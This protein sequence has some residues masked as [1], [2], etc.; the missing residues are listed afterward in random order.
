MKR[1]MFLQIYNIW[2]KLKSFSKPK[3]W[4]W[5]SLNKLDN[6]I[7]HAFHIA[8]LSSEWFENYKKTLASEE[9]KNSL[10]YKFK[11][12]LRRKINIFS[13][14]KPIKKENSNYDEKLEKRTEIDYNQFITDSLIADTLGIAEMVD[15]NEVMKDEEKYS[16]SF[17]NEEKIN[18]KDK[19]ERKIENEINSKKS[20]KEILFNDKYNKV[21][22]TSVA[23]IYIENKDFF[24]LWLDKK[25]ESQDDDISGFNK[26]VNYLKS[27]KIP[28]KILVRDITLDYDNPIFNTKITLLDPT[29]KGVKD[30]Y[31]NF[32]KQ[33]W[34]N[35][36]KF[37]N[38]K[39]IITE[40]KRKKIPIYKIFYTK[41]I[42][43]F[44]NFQITLRCTSPIR[45]EELSLIRSKLNGIFDISLFNPAQLRLSAIRWNIERDMWYSINGANINYPFA[46]KSFH[47]L[48]CH[49]LNKDWKIKYNKLNNKINFNTFKDILFNN[50][51][52]NKNSIG[53][54]YKYA[55]SFFKKVIKHYYEETLNNYK[56]ITILKE[57][58]KNEN[59][60]R[61]LD[62]FFEGYSLEDIPHWAIK[63][64]EKK[65]PNP[66]QKFFFKTAFLNAKK[67]SKKELNEILSHFLRLEQNTSFTSESFYNYFIA[68]NKQDKI[69]KNTKVSKTNEID[70]FKSYKD[71]DSKEKNKYRNL[72]NYYQK[73]EFKT[74]SIMEVNKDSWV[75]FMKSIIN[76]NSL[77]K[78]Y[79]NIF[80]ISLYFKLKE[81]I[82]NKLVSEKGSNLWITEKMLTVYDKD[83]IKIKET[84][85]YLKDNLIDKNLKL[86]KTS[87]YLLWKETFSYFWKWWID[88]ILE[89]LWNNKNFLIK[90]NIIKEENINIVFKKLKENITKKSWSYII[91]EDE[92]IK[93]IFKKINN[94]TLLKRLITKYTKDYE[95]ERQ[96]DFTKILKNSSDALLAEERKYK[97]HKKN[98]NKTIEIIFTRIRD[99]FNKHYRVGNRFNV[100]R[101]TMYYIKAISSYYNIS[102]YLILDEFERSFANEIEIYN[103]EHKNYETIK[104]II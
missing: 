5:V 93:E 24:S 66:E 77:I 67:E 17:L 87:Y 99:N 76:N 78:E 89:F 70:E 28:Y 53:F 47:S 80:L 84:I 50:H 20:A 27:R 40:F 75:S 6:N 39:D 4:Y 91:Q 23:I 52:V 59:E 73:G 42:D 33:L 29:L 90:E 19:K 31:I 54:W 26:L 38:P 79:Y 37:V 46:V 21:L 65:F 18:L 62:Y 72:F 48:Y 81:K 98:T 95:K 12:A 44:Y 64:V 92:E 11:D 83:I 45:L 85:R 43:N 58:Y 22:Y 103:K 60:K 69:K 15:I 8:Y 3:W 61:L 1:E 104:K 74:I 36:K 82:I 13:T 55:K 49:S 86:F 34:K 100:L 35:N 41:G 88:K 10:A 2:R 14:K 97:I 71:L 102:P 9:E 94:N 57:M 101:Y 51:F 32:L 25:I 16:L 63:K 68:W 96:D 7:N 30:G 56:A